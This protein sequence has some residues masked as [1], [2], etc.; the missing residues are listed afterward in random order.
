MPPV[1]NSSVAD[2]APSGAALTKYDEEHAVSYI[3]MLDADKDGPDWSE[4][5]RIL[6]CIDP[7]RELDRARRAYE[8]HL[9]RAK[10][11]ARTGHRLLLRQGG[12]S[13]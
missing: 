6:L 13:R 2:L 8:T 10:W 12:W 1:V 5:A 3:R 4:V 11:M 9:A 7:D